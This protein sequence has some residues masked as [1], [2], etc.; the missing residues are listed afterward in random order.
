MSRSN[1]TLC[2]KKVPT[3]KLFA[4]L[5]NFNRFLNFCTAVKRMTF[6][7]KTYDITHLT[8]G[9]LLHYLGKLNIYIFCRY[10]ADMKEIA[11]K[12][13]F[14]YTNFNSPVC[15]TVYPKRI[16][17]FLSKSCPCH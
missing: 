16:Y 7:T 15:V 4:T 12:F 3:F 17:V 5:S 2:L 11:N 13:Y 14:K 1:N 10:S 8:L 6:A 9:I